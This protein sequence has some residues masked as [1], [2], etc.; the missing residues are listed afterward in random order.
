MISNV[1]PPR[2]HSMAYVLEDEMRFNFHLTTHAE[3][4]FNPLTV[5]GIR[6]M[7]LIV[8]YRI[9][10]AEDMRVEDHLV[11]EWTAQVA[12]RN[13]DSGRLWLVLEWTGAEVLIDVRKISELAD[14]LPCTF[15]EADSMH[16]AA[17]RLVLRVRTYILAQQE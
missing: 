14:T 2:A 9:V 6:T 17:K 8:G 12:P 5:S 1:V 15:A 10:D 7:L 11:L 13:T 3:K 4:S 16:E